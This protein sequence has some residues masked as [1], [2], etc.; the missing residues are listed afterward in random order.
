MTRALARGFTLL[1]MLVTVSILM[2]AGALILVTPFRAYM[3][4]R[5]AS[6]AASTLAQDLALLERVAQNGGVNDG[7]T[8]K[9]VSTNPLVYDCYYGRPNSI[10]PN[11]ALGPV[12]FHRSFDDVALTA[13]PI[14]TS[15]PLLFA[16][17]GSAQYVSAG[18]WAD[19]HQTIRMTLT[20]SADATRESTV[21]LDLFTGSI[22][23]P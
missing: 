4:A 6:D 11:S 13:G 17:N 22:S 15:T 23:L 7:A 5:A 21:D 3:H 20:A 2:I 12:I 19:Q 8:L 9:I 1:E 16:S 18:T 14:D 10:D